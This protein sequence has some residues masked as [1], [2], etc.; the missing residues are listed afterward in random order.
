MELAL[1]SQH[2]TDTLLVWKVARPKTALN[3]SRVTIVTTALNAEA[4]SAAPGELRRSDRLWETWVRSRIVQG[5]GSMALLSLALVARCC[6]TGCLEITA[7][8]DV[9]VPR[10]VMYMY[11]SPLSMKARGVPT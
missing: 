5:S 1:A 10:R 2:G 11:G 4:E 6:N 8:F 7:P 9:C 3:G